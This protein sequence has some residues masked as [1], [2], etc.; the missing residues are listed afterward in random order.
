LRVDSGRGTVK[1]PTLIDKTW[2]RKFLMKYCG[3]RVTI[4]GT[5]ITS[6][7]LIDENQ[8]YAGSFCNKSYMDVRH[9]SEIED[10]VLAVEVG[11]LCMEMSKVWLVCIP[12]LPKASSVCKAIR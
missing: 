8:T 5:E 4:D 6:A 1:T 2:L 3:S 10:K 9:R 12:T 11:W 7:D